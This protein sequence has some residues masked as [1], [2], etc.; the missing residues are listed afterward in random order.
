MN[1]LKKIWRKNM[2]FFGGGTSKKMPLKN[3]RLQRPVSY[4]LVIPMTNSFCG[5]SAFCCT[6]V[7]PHYHQEVFTLLLAR[8]RRGRQHNCSLE[9][10]WELFQGP[11]SSG[12]KRL[13][14]RNFLCG[15][16]SL[17]IWKFPQ[18]ITLSKK[19]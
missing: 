11:R 14:G 19:S 16:F 2:F 15:N 1:L 3:C 9:L 8:E 4:K 18:K 10:K 6:I 7:L 17:E 5:K 13:K 12:K